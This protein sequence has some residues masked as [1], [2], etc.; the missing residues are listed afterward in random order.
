MKWRGIKWFFS[1]LKGE[2]ARVVV[3][4]LVERNFTVKFNS[5]KLALNLTQRLD[6]DSTKTVAN[7]M[8]SGC[9]KSDGFLILRKTTDGALGEL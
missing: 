7:I 2:R 6:S 4:F 5:C 1:V 9:K 3:P 8:A